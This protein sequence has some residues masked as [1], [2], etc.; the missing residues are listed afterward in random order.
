MKYQISQS[1]FPSEGEKINFMYDGKRFSGIVETIDNVDPDV[2]WIEVDESVNYE[3][4]PV[5]YENGNMY[6]NCL[7]EDIVQ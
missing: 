3:N 2:I 4:L 5:V 6:Y 7:I 1:F